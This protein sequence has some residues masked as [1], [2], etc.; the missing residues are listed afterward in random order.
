MDCHRSVSQ[1]WLTKLGPK[2]AHSATSSWLPKPDSVTEKWRSTMFE[3]IRLGLSEAAG[4]HSSS[5]ELKQAYNDNYVDACERLQNLFDQIVSTDKSGE[6]KLV[7]SKA[8][9]LAVDIGI[10]RARLDLTLPAPQRP[11]TQAM[12]AFE[13]CRE[14]GIHGS[15][16]GVVELLVAPGLRKT[17]DIRGGAM[18]KSADL[19][20]AL[21]CLSAEAN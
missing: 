3:T 16:R 10:S 15:E 1:T 18:D 12:C 8:Q 7:A 14:R 2:P 11:I 13:D 4:L 20:P 17:G 6:I 5:A 21:V 9:G 19:L